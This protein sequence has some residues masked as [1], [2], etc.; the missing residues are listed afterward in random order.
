MLSRKGTEGVIV[1]M[2]IM[3][4]L[5][6][7]LLV[8]HQPLMSDAAHYNDMAALLLKGEPFVPYWPPGLPLYLSAVHRVLG[9]ST[10]VVRLAMLVFYAGSSVFVYRTAVLLSASLV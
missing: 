2:G 5:L 1:S 10:L 6:F 7:L 3:I 4:R 9:E 8:A